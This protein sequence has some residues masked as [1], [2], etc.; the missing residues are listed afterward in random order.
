VGTDEFSCFW[1]NKKVVVDYRQTEPGNPNV[2]SLQRQE[3]KP[4]DALPFP[5]DRINPFYAPHQLFQLAAFAPLTLFFPV[6][7]RR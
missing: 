7:D 1:T 2:M 3:R 4:T 5:R 6:P